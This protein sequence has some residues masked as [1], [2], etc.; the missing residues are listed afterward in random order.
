MV[1]AVVATAFGLGE[2]SRDGRGPVDVELL[3]SRVPSQFW[4]PRVPCLGFMFHHR[5]E[6]LFRPIDEILGSRRSDALVAPARGP[7]HMKGP[8]LGPHHAGIAHQLSAYLGLEKRPSLFQS[9]PL[10][11][12][13]A[14]GQQQ[15]VLTIIDEV[16]EEVGGSGAFLGIGQGATTREEYG[17]DDRGIELVQHLMR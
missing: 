6:L 17:G 2:A 13:V 16:G 15:A 8:V 1:V 12:I 11:A 9:L 4:G 5:H 14:L 7:H 3:R 10:Q